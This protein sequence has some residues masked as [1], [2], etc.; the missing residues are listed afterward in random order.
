MTDLTAGDQIDALARLWRWY[1][2]QFRRDSAVYG[3]IAEAIAD[4][5]GV[6]TMLSEAPPAAHLPL[7]PR[8]PTPPTQTFETVRTSRG[9]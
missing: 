6:I 9:P 8:L 2:E 5:R 4:D 7:T 3:R 1:G